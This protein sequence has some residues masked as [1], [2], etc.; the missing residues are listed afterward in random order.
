M[1]THAGPVSPA[2]STLSGTSSLG[3]T[4]EPPPKCPPLAMLRGRSRGQS[5]D[6]ARSAS[7][8]TA[9]G[10]VASA[11]RTR[12]V[13]AYPDARP[14][15]AA[16]GTPDQLLDA[17]LAAAAAALPLTSGQQQKQQQHDTSSAAATATAAAS[18]LDLNLDRRLT[19]ET[20]TSSNVIDDRGHSAQ[21]VDNSDRGHSAQRVDKLIVSHDRGHS[22]QQVAELA[23]NPDRSPRARQVEIK[24]VG[25]SVLP[26]DR[27]FCAQLVDTVSAASSQQQRAATARNPCSD[28][29]A[30][31]TPAAVDTLRAPAAVDGPGAAGTHGSSILFPLKTGGNAG[32]NPTAQVHRIRLPRPRT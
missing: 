22:A 9:Y 11:S 6:T 28:G 7:T 5:Y 19:G 2:R 31:P 16:S 23:L 29:V 17:A 26:S 20:V 18:I 8:E 30:G 13:L 12:R 4:P 32:Q 25:F 15:T 3:L 14:K 1:D 21:R 27:G 10:R 24:Q